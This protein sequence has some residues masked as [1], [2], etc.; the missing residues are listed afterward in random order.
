MADGSIEPFTIATLDL[1]RAARIGIVRL[2]GRSGD[3]VGDIAAIRDWG[4]KAVVSMTELSEM[5]AKGAGDL[6]ALLAASGIAHLHF[7]IRDFGAPEQRDQR[8]PELAGVVHSRLDAGE[9]VLLHCMGGHGR[10]GMVALRLLVERGMEPQAALQLVRA[11]RPGA[12]E[13]AAQEAWG[14]GLAGEKRDG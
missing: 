14:K 11:E 13:T 10:S 5:A 7:P 4:A 2:P 9:A 6:A 1:G 8:W 3:L 12:V